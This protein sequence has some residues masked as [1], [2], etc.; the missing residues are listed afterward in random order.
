VKAKP[1]NQHAIF[2]SFSQLQTDRTLM[3]KMLHEGI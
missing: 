3:E 2:S 1:D